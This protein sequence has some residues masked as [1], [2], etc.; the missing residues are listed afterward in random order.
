M[1]PFADVHRGREKKSVGMNKAS[2]FGSEKKK[3]K[4]GVF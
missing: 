1:I 2:L 4:I 3:G